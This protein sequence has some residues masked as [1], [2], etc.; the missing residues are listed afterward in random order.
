M[1]LLK[2]K[3]NSSMDTCYDDIFYI[4]YADQITS[5]SD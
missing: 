4:S 2:N 1:E 3:D 5:Q